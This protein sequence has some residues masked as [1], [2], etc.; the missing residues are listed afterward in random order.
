[1][2]NAASHA[3]ALQHHKDFGFD[4]SPAPFNWPV[5]K[6]NRDAYIKKLNGIYESNLNKSKVEIIKGTATFVDKKTVDVGGQKYQG[7]HILIATGG[8]P[9]MPTVP[10]AEYGISSDGFFELED[11]PKR[12]VVVGAG[13]IAVE[14]A[15]ILKTLGSDVTMLI[16]RDHVLRTFDNMISDVITK[17]LEDIGIKLMKHDNITSAS[18]DAQGALTVITNSGK[19]LPNIDCLLFAIGRDPNVGLGLDKIGVAL[20]RGHIQVDAFQNTTA[21]GVYALGDV[22]GRALLT[23]VAIA[24]GRRLAHRLFDNQPDLKLDYENI[25][26]VVFS[27]PPSASVGLTEAEAR[28]RHQQVRVYTSSFAPLYY[29]LSEHKVKTHMKLVCAGAE[30]RVVGLHMVGQA[31]DEMLQGFAVAVKMGATKA[32]FDECVAIHPTSSEELVTMR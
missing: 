25:P 17:G 1:M 31:V 11:L 29:A 14:M 19:T 4:V 32:Q 10:G 20:S 16:R 13:Y 30:E 26:S 2:F 18:R 22:C 6:K 28:E 9:S 27:H 7:D 5:V 21:E 3:E 24:A 15:G 8:R 23:P 12:T